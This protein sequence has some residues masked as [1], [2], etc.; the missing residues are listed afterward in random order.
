MCN[1]IAN[2]SPPPLCTKLVGPFNAKDKDTS[3]KRTENARLHQMQTPQ[4]KRFPR[5]TISFDTFTVLLVPEIYHT[6]EGFLEFF[7]VVGVV[8][9]FVDLPDHVPCID[10]L[11]N[12]FHALPSLW[13]SSKSGMGS[14]ALKLLQVG[15]GTPFSKNQS[16]TLPTLL[17]RE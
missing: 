10:H 17:K 2:V 6:F 9:K 16:P 15:S 8:V 12:K 1:I 3:Q 5:E 7:G 4:S 14:D 11:G 13:R